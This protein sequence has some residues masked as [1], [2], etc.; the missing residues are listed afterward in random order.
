MTTAT[1]PAT[2]TDINS[3][4]A[5]ATNLGSLRQGTPGDVLLGFFVPIA[6]DMDGAN[7]VGER[8][9]MITNG[10]NSNSATSAE[11]RQSIRIDF[12]L[13]D[14]GIDSLLRLSRETGFVE[15]VSLISDGGSLYH[16]NLILD[17]GVGDLFKYNDGAPFVGVPE[18]SAVAGFAL[19]LA[20]TSLRRRR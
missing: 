17:G 8:Y 5:T 18:P 16:L 9:F 2:G 20:L 12:D 19:S 1:D 14:S 4:Y 3:S 6:E 13:G 15:E 11:A 10:L 7:F